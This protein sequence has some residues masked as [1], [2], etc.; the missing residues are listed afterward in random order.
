MVGVGR[1]PWGHHRVQTPAESRV[2]QGRLVRTTTSQV[3]DASKDGDCN[4]VQCLITPTVKNI[5]LVVKWN[6]CISVCAHCPPSCHGAPLRRMARLHSPCRVFPHVD[7]IPL[8]LL[9]C[10]NTPSS[11]SPSPCASCSQP[12]IIFLDLHL[13]QCNV[14]MSL[15]HWSWLLLRWEMYSNLTNN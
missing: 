15:V 11:L 3:L 14:S 12:F 5:F 1:G 7:N 9:F 8:S 6:S 4:L 13:M 2:N 10:L